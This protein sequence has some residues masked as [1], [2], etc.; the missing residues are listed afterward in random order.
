MVAMT[1]SANNRR[2]AEHRLKNNTA[3]LQRADEL[4][5]R[6]KVLNKVVA[7]KD[8]PGTKWQPNDDGQNPDRWD[9]STES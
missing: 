9:K 3:T 2:S 5:R 1:K 6:E 8:C 4:V 7:I